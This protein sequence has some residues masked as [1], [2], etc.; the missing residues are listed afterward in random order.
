MPATEGLGKPA[1]QILGRIRVLQGSAQVGG[2]EDLRR[3]RALESRAMGEQRVVERRVA[4]TE[5]LGQIFRRLLLQPRQIGIKLAKQV[6]TQ[7]R[8]GMAAAKT[9]HTRLLEDII[10]GEDIVGALA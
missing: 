4:C 9:A 7:A 3:R 8:S 2:E 6:R 1:G 5:K 10:A